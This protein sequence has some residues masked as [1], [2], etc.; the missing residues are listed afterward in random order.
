MG[1]FGVGGFERCHGLSIRPDQIEIWSICGDTLTIHAFEPEAVPERASLALPS[2]G[3][4]I[5]SAP[6]SRF[7]YIAL[8]GG[9]RSP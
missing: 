8:A 6:D 1:R 5:T 9:A 3:Y 4:W 2:K 7:A